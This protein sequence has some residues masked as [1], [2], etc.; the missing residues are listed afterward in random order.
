MKQKKIMTA[1][2]K[3]YF[4]ACCFPPIGRGNS[5][6]NACVAN[7]L[8]EDFDVQVICMEREDGYLLSYQEDQ[9]LVTG[10]NPRLTVQRVRQAKWGGMNVALYALGLLPCYYLNWAWKVW[11]RRKELIREPG[12][13]FAVY[14][15]FSDLVVARA[16]SKRYGYP[17]LVDFRDDFAGVM[18][19]G[20]R[21]VLGGFYR[22]MERWVIRQADAVTVTTE[23]LKQD[24]MKRYRLSE[25]RIRVVYNVV[26]SAPDASPK[27]RDERSSMRVIYAG[28]I[29]SI[30][31]PEI[32][33]KAYGQLVRVN[34]ELPERVKVEIYGPESPYFSMH[35]KKYLGPGCSYGGFIP[36][37]ETIEKIAAADIGFLALGDATYAYATP[38]KLFEYIE[39]GVPMVAVLP[40]GAARD[41]I[42]SHQ[43]GLVADLGDI[44]R[45]AECIG[46]MIA[47]EE[48]RERCRANMERIRE[49]FRPEQQVGRWREL[50]G[51][52]AREQESRIGVSRTGSSEGMQSTCLAGLK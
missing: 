40:P 3:I 41:L 2:S 28:A 35:V 19:R 30:Q 18:S 22:L 6:T 16:L 34:A 8:S 12:I 1:K 26:P 45:L 39:L 15:V 21:R 29:S 42:E 43:I 7:H 20:W 46:E 25:E 23:T 48:L 4:L 44:Q 9:S 50:L 37:S 11:R 38:T 17:L 49:Q 31:R 33:L 13:I 36:H 47:S 32:L 5:I 51:E 52:L 10:L 14:P 27:S 24:L